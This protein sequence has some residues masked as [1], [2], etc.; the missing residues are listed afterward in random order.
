MHFLFHSSSIIIILVVVGG[1][2]LVS[3]MI[4]LQGHSFQL[5]LLEHCHSFVINILTLYLF[6]PFLFGICLLLWIILIS[7]FLLLFC[8]I[9]VGF[10]FLYFLSEVESNS[11]FGSYKSPNII[12]IFII[13]IYSV[14]HFFNIASFIF[15]SFKIMISLWR[16]FLY[17]P[18][19]FF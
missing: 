2:L 13:H 14:H 12:I 8:C 19:L 6:L 4:S 7:Q 15:Q 11:L 3:I 1:Q 5:P 17:F 9:I 10:C 16:Y 18:N